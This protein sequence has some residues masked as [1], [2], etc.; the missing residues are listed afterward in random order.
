MIKRYKAKLYNHL[1]AVSPVQENIPFQN[2][3]DDMGSVSLLK[4]NPL[5]KT[6]IAI[7][8]TLNFF[9]NSIPIGF[10][11]LPL[12]LQTKIPLFLFGLTDFYS[13][14]SKILNLIPLLNPWTD[15]DSSYRESAELVDQANWNTIPYWNFV[16]DIG[17]IAAGGALVN[18]GVALD[19]RL[20]RANFWQIGHKYKIVIS[21]RET[22][23]NAFSYFSLYDGVNNPIQIVVNSENLIFTYIPTT[24]TL[25]LR[26]HLYNGAVV[27]LSIKEIFGMEQY[28]SNPE[29]GIYGYTKSFALSPNVQKGDCVLTY[30][31]VDINGVV[32]FNNIYNA[33]IIIHSDNVA[34]GTF[35]N[36]FVS[37]LITISAIRYI[38]PIANI[39][40]F[41]NPL[42][43]GYQTLF[44]KATSDSIDPRNYITSKDFQQQ[45]CDIPLN[46]PIDKAVTCGMYMDF[47]CPQID[48][49]L[50]VSKVEPL[51]HK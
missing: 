18:N 45:I 5:T 29:F 36:S 8:A 2:V 22:A 7:T 37:D 28:P 35:L 30:N 15:N 27:S 34:Y 11:V 12:F 1:N 48:F 41:I 24:T 19:S 21:V 26:S 6:E 17:W 31:F 49:I 51:T 16:A 38:V 9:V 39:N 47:N 4:G 10:A 3:R 32:P 42:V 23:H 20:G 50:F 43:I 13:G 25:Y 40:Q 33:E 14:Y 46:L 44:G